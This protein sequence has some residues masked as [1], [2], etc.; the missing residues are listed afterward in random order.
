MFHLNPIV[1]TVRVGVERVDI[2][3]LLTI[4][5]PDHSP[6]VLFRGSALCIVYKLLSKH[7]LFSEKKTMAS[8]KD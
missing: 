7:D 2:L 8:T 1:N 3:P 6:K 4:V 5:H